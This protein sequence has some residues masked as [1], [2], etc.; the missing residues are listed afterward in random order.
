[1]KRI[2][3]SVATEDRLGKPMFE[4]R[5]VYQ[6]SAVD[7]LIAELKARCEELQ[8]RCEEL[9][10]SRDDWH[11]MADLRGDEIARLKGV[12]P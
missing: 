12:N 8:A 5:W 3:I 1:M 4:K 9:D 7:S 11:R 10:R 2:E 6:A